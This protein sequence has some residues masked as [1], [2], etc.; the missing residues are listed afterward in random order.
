MK[1]GLMVGLLSVLTVLVFASW[2]APNA[3]AAF[4][5]IAILNDWNNT[6]SQNSG[7]YV[8]VQIGSGTDAGKLRVAFLHQAGASPNPATDPLSTGGTIDQFYWNASAILSLTGWSGIGGNNPNLDNPSGKAD[9]F[10]QDFSKQINTDTNGKTGADATVLI[11]TIVS[12]S[13]GNCF[14]AH[15]NEKAG[16]GNAF[17]ANCGVT[18][19][20]PISLL[21]LGPG[22]L[23]IGLVKRRLSSRK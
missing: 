6:A 21:L 23:A 5:T 19:P 18:T 2:S 14:A 7:D 20:E 22:L 3:E 10:P 4:T 13:V 8:V 15:I 16:P 9:G 11:F 1:R 17:V 12:G